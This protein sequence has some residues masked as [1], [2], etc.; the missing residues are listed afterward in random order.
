MR[1]LQHETSQTAFYAFGQTQRL[2]GT[3]HKSLFV[4]FSCVFTFLE[5]LQHNIPKML[6]IFF[7]PV[8]KWLHKNSPIL[9]SFLK[10]HSDMAAV[11]MQSN[12][13][14]TNEVKDNQALLEPY[15]GKNQTF[16]PTQYKE[17]SFMS[18][19]PNGKNME[20]RSRGPSVREQGT[21]P[22]SARWNLALSMPVVFTVYE[23]Y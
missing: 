18:S 5:I 7:H 15:Y 20:N 6:H 4:C 2:L 8:L 23:A 16:W 11:T 10:M 21:S 3:L 9:V 19:V 1:S 22:C 17:T 13:T 14:V 12:K